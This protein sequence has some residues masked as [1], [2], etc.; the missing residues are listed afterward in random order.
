MGELI[1]TLVMLFIT[2]LTLG[3]SQCML[4][5]APV[6][7]F[8]VAGTAEGW[9]EGLRATLVFSLARLLAYTVLGALAGGLGMRLLAY[10]REE[11]LITWVKLGT[12]AFILLMGILILMGRNPHLHLCRYLSRHT[13][14]NST[15]SMALLGFS[16]GIVPYCASFLGILTYIAFV[17]KDLLLGALCGL[18]FGFGAA[19]VTPL[20][21]VGPLTGVIPKLFKSPLLLEVFRR[22]SGGI[23]LLFGIR[24]VL[25]I[26]ERL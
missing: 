8:Y 9:R 13:L 23:L 25:T 22:A 2:E 24:L 4:S 10:F 20:I 12:A 3:M 19:L 14:K 26:L 21:V 1:S 17:L 6:L 15:L 16:I 7:T 11:A 18:F 5:W